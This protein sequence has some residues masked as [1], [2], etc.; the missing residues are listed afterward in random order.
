[1][2]IR[3][4]NPSDRP[5]PRP[6]IKFLIKSRNCLASGY[7]TVSGIWQRLGAELYFFFFF[8]S[9]HDYFV[10]VGLYSTLNT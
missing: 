10:F 5:R 1:M 9:F 6:T 8:F 2:L 3:H 4:Y 7:D